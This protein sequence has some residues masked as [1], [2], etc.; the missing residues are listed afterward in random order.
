MKPKPKHKSKLHA[1]AWLLLAFAPAALYGEL[2]IITFGPEVPLFS[3]EGQ[4]FVGDQ[5]EAFDV[6]EEGEIS[7]PHPR[8][9]IALSGTEERD[10]FIRGEV[11]LGGT[12]TNMRYPEDYASGF[13]FFVREIHSRHR[14]ELNPTRIRNKRRLQEGEPL[15]RIRTVFRFDEPVLEEWTPFAALVTADRLVFQIGDQVGR[16]AGPVDVDG[17]NLIGIAPG[18]KIRNVRLAL[19]EGFDETESPQAWE[20]VE[21]RTWTDRKGRTMHAELL[22]SDEAFVTVRRAHDGRVF[23]VQL[24]DLSEE[25]RQFVRTRHDAPNPPPEP[26]QEKGEP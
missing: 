4:R 23:T 26:E 16:V 6:S 13:T 7:T 17:R 10:F 15:H 19:V 1:C 25:D 20:G 18:S 8:R 14:Y 21:T 2:R 3:E 5:L 12:Y 9:R 22:D 11:F 24:E